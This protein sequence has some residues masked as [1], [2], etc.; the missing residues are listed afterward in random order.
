MIT[1]TSV[2]TA[3][4]V[5]MENCGMSIRPILAPAVGRCNMATSRTRHCPGRGRAIANLLPASAAASA[6]SIAATAAPFLH[7]LEGFHAAAH[8]VELLP[9]RVAVSLVAAGAV[10]SAAGAGRRAGGRRRRGGLV[11]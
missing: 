1:A 10:A 4:S 5:R 3:N 11:L 6:A 8:L 9:S 7:L 2:V